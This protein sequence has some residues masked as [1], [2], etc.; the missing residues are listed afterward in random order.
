MGSRS[1][2]IRLDR[3]FFRISGQIALQ[4]HENDPVF[5]EKPHLPTETHPDRSANLHFPTRIAPE[6]T[7]NG[8][9]D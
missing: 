3:A 1:Y 4:R 7:Q 8:S 2:E 6:P 9:Y 5:D